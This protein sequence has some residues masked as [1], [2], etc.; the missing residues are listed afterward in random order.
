MQNKKYEN[1]LV[2]A[3]LILVLTVLASLV[4]VTGIM[5]RRA[6]KNEGVD[7]SPK[8]TTDGR[9]TAEHDPEVTRPTFGHKDEETTAPETTAPATNGPSE[10]VGA[11]SELPKFIAPADG[12]VSKKHSET[13]LVYSLTMDDYRT[14]TGVDIALT[15]GAEV[16]A[17]A[18][19]IVDKVWE[20]PMWGWCVSVVHEGDAQSIYKNLTPESAGHLKAGVELAAGEAIGSVGDSA[21]CEIA[22]EPHLH[23]ELVIGGVS[24]DPEEYITF[25][26]EDVFAEG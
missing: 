12:A 1:R 3:A 15:E 8:V 2:Y 17:V 10:D 4:I 22:D 7:T 23:F 21:L 20:D 19:G 25:A 9:V 6:N 16:K 18:D 24:V 14:H 26:A 5:S 11:P 13:T